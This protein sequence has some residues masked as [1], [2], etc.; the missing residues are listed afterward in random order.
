MSASLSGSLPG[1]RRGQALAVGLTAVVLAV[2]WLGIASPA[3][4]WFA[5]RGDLLARRQALAAKMASVAATTPALQ[6]QVAASGVAPRSALL[7]GASEAIASAV[8]Q[9][10]L[11][12]MCDRAGV[13]LT[14]AEALAAEPA[15][16]YRRIRVRAA[17]TGPWSRLV[18]LL[19]DVQAATPRMLVDDLQVGASR[20]ITT[21][22]V[23]PLDVTFTAIALYA[24]K[25][26]R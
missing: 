18:A 1:G 4:G 22:A 16:P 12:Q 5:D 13:R 26:P 21:D 15:G 23:K 17:V 3:L 25:P 20:T 10:R 7:E 9:Q 8:L 6:R 19:A 14:S 11:Q 24:G 2:A